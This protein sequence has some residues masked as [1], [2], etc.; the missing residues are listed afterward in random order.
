MRLRSSGVAGRRRTQKFLFLLEELMEDKKQIPR[1]ALTCRLAMGIRAVEIF[2][3]HSEEFSPEARELIARHGSPLQWPGFH[4]ALTDGGIQ[5]YQ[6]EPF[7]LDHRFVQR[8]VRGR[9]HSAPPDPAPAGAAQPG[10][11]YR[12][13]G[14]GGTRGRLIKDGA[15][16]VKFFGEMVRC[17]RRLPRWKFQRSRRRGRIAGV[18][19]HL[20]KDS[21]EYPS[22]VHGEADSAEALARPSSKSWNGRWTYRNTSRRSR[23]SKS[24]FCLALAC[25]CSCLKCHPEQ[26]EGP[27]RS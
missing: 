6:P 19:G 20:Q 27:Q 17:G 3:K 4:F 5:A 7:P 23:W 14:G 22:V 21:A 24:G 12:L 8:N 15:S 2:L 13:P 26:S 9:A 16:E 18:A 1:A 11:V 10:F 25:L